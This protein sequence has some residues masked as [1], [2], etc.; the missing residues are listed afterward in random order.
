VSTRNIPA[1]Q[2]QRCDRMH[3]L[4]QWIVSGL[5]WAE[6]VCFLHLAVRCGLFH[7]WILQQHLISAVLFLPHGHFQCHSKPGWVVQSLHGFLRAWAIPVRSMQRNSQSELCALSHGHGAGCL[8][9]AGV[10][11]V[12][13]VGDVPKP[14]GDNGV[15]VMHQLVWGGTVRGRQLHG[16]AVAHVLGV[17][18]RHRQPRRWIGVKLC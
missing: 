14:H 5:G 13:R 10:V 16:V 4:Q 12:V 8:G 3:F 6:H 2:R 7:V 17:S 1:S 15:S 11:S 18:A 9:L